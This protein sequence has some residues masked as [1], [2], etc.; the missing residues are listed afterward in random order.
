MSKMSTLT[1]RVTELLTRKRLTEK[2]IGAATLNKEILKEIGESDDAAQQAW[3]LIFLSIGVSSLIQTIA[4]SINS[5]A[6]SLIA[7]YI[8]YRAGIGA[9]VESLVLSLIFGFVLVFAWA[10]ILAFVGKIG[11]GQTVSAKECIPYVGFATV[12]PFILGSIILLIGAASESLIPLSNIVALGLYAWAAA[13]VIQGYSMR[14]GMLREISAASVIMAI[15]IAFILGVN[16]QFLIG[17]I[18]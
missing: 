17:K 9:F 10:W 11:F 15:I 13:I 18:I 16:A 6:V 1:E 2:I 4:T 8:Q 3:L 12:I 14:S 7:P 5:Q